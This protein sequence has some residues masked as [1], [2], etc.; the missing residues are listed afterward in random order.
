MDDSPRGTDQ[1]QA[2]LKLW[3]D[4]FVKF[5]Q[6]AFAFSPEATPPESL[7]QIRS[8]LL[9]SMTQAWDEYLRSPLFLQSSRQLY[10][11]SFE[12]Q[13]YQ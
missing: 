4:S 5:S 3:T 7:K 6:A 10:C 13:N 8:A 12:H 1:V 9:Q 11:R 2:L